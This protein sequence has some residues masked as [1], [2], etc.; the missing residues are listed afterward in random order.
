MVDASLAGRVALSSACELSIARGH[1]R[2][3]YMGLAGR[4]LQ[5]TARLTNRPDRSRCC[6]QNFKMLAPHD[7]VLGHA[8]PTA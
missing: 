1:D 4:T 2:F 6:L 3:G 5:H 8:R 7:Q